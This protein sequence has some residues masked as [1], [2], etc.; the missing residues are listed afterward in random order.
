MKTEQITKVTMLRS[1]E[2][3]AVGYDT[4]VAPTEFN[5]MQITRAIGRLCSG[6]TLCVPSGGPAPVMDCITLVSDGVPYL[7]VYRI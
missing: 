3:N 4:Y 2:Q 5:G 6:S 1:S 7:A